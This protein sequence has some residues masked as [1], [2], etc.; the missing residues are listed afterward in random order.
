[1]NSSET[2]TESNLSIG[3]GLIVFALFLGAI[4]CW[5]SYF[6]PSWGAIPGDKG[7]DVFYDSI[8]YNLANYGEFGLNFNDLE[9][10]ET[11]ETH[12]QNGEYDWI[13]LL[14]ADGP[15]TSRAPGFPFAVAGVY[16]M[17]GR[18]F[19][20]VR[21]FNMLVLAFG[22]TWLIMSVQ[23]HFGYLAAAIATA[24]L[25]LDFGILA[26]AGYLVSEPLGTGLM[27][28]TF[29][30]VIWAWNSPI[31]RKRPSWRWA[32]VGL[33]FGL[34]MMVRPPV[35]IWLMQL[36][37]LVVLATLVML[38]RRRSP[39]RLLQG[40][41]LF[42]LVVMLVAS[43]WWIRNCKVANQFAP[44]GSAGSFGCL[45]GYS[46]E[47]FENWGNWHAPV[48]VRRQAQTIRERDL[49]EMNLAQEEMVMGRDGTQEAMDWINKNRHQL[50]KLM[51]MK[52]LNHLALVQQAD[53]KIPIANALILIGALIGVYG[54][55][56]RYGFWIA[57]VTFL[58]LATTVVTW[59]HNGRFAIPIRPIWHVGCALGILYFWSPR[60]RKLNSKA[61]EDTSGDMA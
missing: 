9:W 33:L 61:L 39:L 26:N 3:F 21:V 12:N 27:A 49:S 4:Y 5:I 38:I 30:L 58:S 44:L 2:Q 28:I 55:W 45:G 51:G 11:Y 20:M 31:E 60:F 15:T 16:R 54:T 36:L 34:T 42:F 23:R 7:D 14:N 41:F 46:D 22:L 57:L 43:P 37:V 48:V 47:T 50:P 35:V 32:L 53:P 29:S 40:A 10:L 17:L 52:A 18:D 59:S 25:M 1:M 8:A 56:R 24:T 13:F 6:Q 19:D